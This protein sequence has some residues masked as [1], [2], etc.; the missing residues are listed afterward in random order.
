MA[1]WITVHA[2]FDYPWPG[3]SAITAFSDP[4]EYM[5]KDEVADFAVAGGHATE[6]KAEGSATRSRK[7]KTTGPRKSAKA[8]A[9]GSTT[10]ET[11]DNRPDDTVAEPD[12]VVPDQPVGGDGVDQDAG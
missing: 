12:M 10:A 1:R 3:R 11:A 9:K 8:A 2:A 7:G 6:G 5:V 4:G